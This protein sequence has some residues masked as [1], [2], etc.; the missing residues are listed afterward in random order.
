MKLSKNLILASNSPRRKQI[1]F[2]AGFEFTISVKEIDESFPIEM[3]VIEVAEYLAIKKAKSFLNEIGDNI[4]LTA[5]TIVAIEGEIL[6]KPANETEATVMLKK[7][8][9]RKHLV[10]T[11]VCILTKNGQESFLDTTEVYFKPLTK[12]EI[13]Y[14]IKACKPFDKAGAYGVQDFIGMIGIDKI[15]GSYFTVMGLPIHK[16]YKALEKYIM[17]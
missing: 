17:F 2:D 15:E 11:G 5:D 4:V 7:L 16:V 3:L 12:N 13:K 1:L 10:H 14:Y 6:N 9:G 8:S